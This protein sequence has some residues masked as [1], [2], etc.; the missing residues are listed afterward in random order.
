MK[1]AVI[2]LAIIVVLVGAWEAAARMSSPLLTAP[3][4]LVVPALAGVLTLDTYPELPRHLLVTVREI[5]VAYALAVLAGL[6][7]GFALGLY[8]TLGRAY[9]PIL[10]ALYA[11]PAV[12]WYPSLMLFFGLD[13]ASKIAFGFLLGFFPITLAVLAGIRQVSPHL[14][15]VAHAFGARPL[16]TF[17]KVMV[18]AMM[19]TLAGGLRTG[20]ALSVIGVIVGEILGSKAGMGSLINHAYGL[21]RTADYVALVLV[22]LVL[23]VASDALASQ[24]EH[25]AQRWSE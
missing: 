17:V 8:R 7:S 4:S 23:I 16:T 2:R 6:G 24:V 20:L 18:P 12:V 9:G 13:S 11:V 21:L 14:V 22:T 15:T 5:A 25:R 1:I 19:F 10:A 3:P